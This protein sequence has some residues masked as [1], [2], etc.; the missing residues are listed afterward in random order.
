MMGS[1][2]SH[3]VITTT[4]SR[5][6]NASVLAIDYR[7]TPENKRVACIEDCQAAYKWILDNR[8][9]IKAGAL[10]VSSLLEIRLEVILL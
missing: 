5:I 7:L 8:P 3:R 6:T 9:D 4:L 10:A 1:P 2:P